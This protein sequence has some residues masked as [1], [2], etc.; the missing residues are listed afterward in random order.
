MYTT[1]IL[2]QEDTVVCTPSQGTC[3][4]V[5]GTTTYHAQK[6]PFQGSYIT[7]QEGCIADSMLK[8]AHLEL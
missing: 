7:P 3:S 1:Y 6:V 2:H 4:A 8:C 5:C